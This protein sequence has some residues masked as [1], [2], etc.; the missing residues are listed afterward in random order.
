MEVVMENMLEG[1]RSQD[2]INLA[3]AVC[4]F[5]S[6]WVVGFAAETVPAW[7]AWSV[8]VVLGMLAIATLAAFAQ[9][10]E[11]ANLLLGLW[12]V[13]S[14]WLLDFATN[15]NAMWTHVVIGGLVAIMSAWAAWDEWQNPH[16]HA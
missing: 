6:P 14:P 12:L 10:E 11:W 5:V 1:R 4:M 8:G 3:L 7:N 9:W 16:A 15:I 13:V 2:W